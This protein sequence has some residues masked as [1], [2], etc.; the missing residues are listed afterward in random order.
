M[1]L[2]CHLTSIGS[3]TIL[4]LLKDLPMQRGEVTSVDRAD[5]AFG[6]NSETAVERS[7]TERNR[8]TV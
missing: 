7:A 5:L 3:P 1:L 8:L 2:P 6:N 4:K